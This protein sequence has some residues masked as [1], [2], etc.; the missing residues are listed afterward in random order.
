MKLNHTY[1]RPACLVLSL[2]LLAGCAA[3]APTAAPTP[4]PVLSDYAAPDYSAHTAADEAGY[5]T[6]LIDPAKLSEGKAALARR[7]GLVKSARVFEGLEKNEVW[8]YDLRDMDASGADLSAVEDLNDISF[9]SDTVWP[10]ALPEGFDPKAILERNKNP[11]LGV[12][13]L[14][15]QG[16]TGE[17]VGVAIIGQAL[18][19]T[20]REYGSRLM[21]Y[22]T[23]HCA[24]PEAMMHGAAVASIAVGQETG[25][26]PGAKL[27]YIASTFGHLTEYGLD[28]DASIAADGI[29]RLLELN[30]ALPEGEKIRVIS[31]PCGYRKGE[32]GY[33]E[34]T[35]AIQKADEAGIFVVTPTTGAFYDFDLMGMD[36]DYLAD[37]DDMASYIPADWARGNTDCYLVP[38]GSRTFA[39]TAGKYQYAISRNGD[40]S[41]AA[42]WFAGLYA[43]GCQV[44]AD[45]TPAAFIEAVK[46]TAVPADFGN[47]VDPA[48]VI[49]ALQSK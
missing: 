11:G 7:E 9:S 48:A 27:Y 4:T 18:F 44:K 6:A 26:A 41:W 22:E 13:A 28:F 29:L 20:H 45:L 37:P 34:L 8:G 35:A 21:S 3:K 32:Q 5:V 1:T 42:P 12:R 31:I 39:S 10:E 23:I 49:G 40:M 25:V 36:R 19:A 24:D 43:L 33:D 47:I 15:E 17:G 30:R 16:I 46:A 38:T 14:H 2:C